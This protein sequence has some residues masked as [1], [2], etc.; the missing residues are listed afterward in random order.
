MKNPFS[1]IDLRL[2]IVIL[3]AVCLRGYSYS[4]MPAGTT[5]F[6]HS[7]N[8]GYVAFVVNEVE[9][10]AP[11]PIPQPDPDPEKCACKGTGIIT[12][13]DGHTTHCPYHYEEEDE[14]D[15]ER[16]WRCK[17][18]TRRTYCNCIATN[19]ECSCKKKQ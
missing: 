11:N 1:A 6:D 10:Q 9:Y 16:N 8:E 12:H 14:D 18:D 17:C 19:G 5:D 13:G 3:L 2:Q 15:G 7:R 4:M